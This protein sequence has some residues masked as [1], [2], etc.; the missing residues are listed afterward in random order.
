LIESQILLT[1]ARGEA[2]DLLWLVT[3]PGLE[4]YFRETGA[5]PGAPPKA[6]TP[7]Q[8]DEI[9]RKHGVRFKH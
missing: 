2:V 1:A 5:P 3:P 4:N 8:V 6:L 9:G 7:A